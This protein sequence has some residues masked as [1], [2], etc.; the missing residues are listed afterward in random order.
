MCKM[1]ENFLFLNHKKQLFRLSTGEK[2][3]QSKKLKYDWF[4]NWHGKNARILIWKL[5]VNYN[6]VYLGIWVY[7]DD[8]ILL[9]PSRSGLQLITNVCE[10]FVSL[11]QLKFSTQM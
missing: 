8:I 1:K 9:S 3:E 6:C 5:V 11:H 2:Y 10:K 7:A 4:E